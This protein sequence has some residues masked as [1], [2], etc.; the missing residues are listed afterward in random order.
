MNLNRLL[1][2]K[3]IEELKPIYVVINNLDVLR[4]KNYNTNNKI[5]YFL[6]FGFK[7]GIHLILINRGKGV[8]PSIVANTKTKIVLKTSSLEQ[9]YDIMGN[10][11]ACFLN[12]NG[13]AL[14]IFDTNIY[15]LQLPYISDSDYHKVIGKFILN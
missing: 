3:K 10:K 14:M 8:E 13:D 12:G 1:T 7:C 15:H 11:N 5:L 6:K 9:S 4:S 2:S